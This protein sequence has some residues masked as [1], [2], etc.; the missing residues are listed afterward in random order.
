MP[1]HFDDAALTR[2]AAG[3]AGAEHDRIAGHVAGCRSCMER[4][5]RVVEAALRDPGTWKLAGSA[6]QDES[7]DLL[8]ERIA[9]EDEEA[10]RLLQPLLD[11]DASA[12]RVVWSNL[13][14]RKRFRTG[15]VGR[16]LAALA[17]DALR[18]EPREA[19][20]LADEAIAI[21]ESLP[22]DHYPADIVYELRGDAWKE[23]AN[24]CR[25][26]GDLRPALDA[27]QH[28]ERAYRHLL[29]PEPWLA[30]VDQIRATVLRISEK[31]DGALVCAMRAAE[32]FARL[33]DMKRFID[34]RI[35]E[36]NVRAEAGDPQSAR[37]ILEPIYQSLDEEAEPETKGT[38]ANNLGH[39]SMDIG[40]VGEASRYFLSALQLWDSLDSPAQGVLTRRNIAYLALVAGNPSEALRR[41]TAALTAAERLGLRKDAELMRL[42]IAEAYLATDEYEG[43][44]LICQH[45]VSSFT[46]AGMSVAARTAAAHLQEAAKRRSLSIAKIRHVRHFLRRLEEQPQ[47]VFAEAR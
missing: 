34:A 30:A 44:A 5:G 45:L 47:L 38:I 46:A 17:H 35:V 16:L 8:A 36:A 40:D 15:G 29:F 27:L 23:R 9:R 24:A 13:P 4:L 31:Y 6:E 43:A 32:E 37:A 28:A 21:S 1:E 26:L 33:G 22:D 11:G 18:R 25:Y 2:Y 3:R 12:L 14:R 39:Y 19:L 42:D 20:H 10:R 41:L 7:Y